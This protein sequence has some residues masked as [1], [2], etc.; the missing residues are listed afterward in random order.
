MPTDDELAELEEQ[1]AQMAKE[2][3]M[4]K[5]K[6]WEGPKVDET[7]ADR[8]RASHVV[9]T[10]YP[11]K[12]N[13]EW[14]PFNLV[15]HFDD[16]KILRYIVGQ[17]E[18]CPKTN[19]VHFQGYC[20]LKKRVQ[21]RKRIQKAL[22]AGKCWC[23][24]AMG[25][26][27]DNFNYC[28]KEHWDGKGNRMAGTQVFEWGKPVVMKG[29]RCDLDDVKLRL[30]AGDNL[31]D[32]AQEH[33][34]PFIKYHKGFEKYQFMKK[35]AEA[36]D[37]RNIKVHVHYGDAGSNKSRSAVEAAGGDYYRP[38]VNKNGQ[39]WFSAYKGEKTLILDDFYGQIP[40]NYLLRL[41]DGHKLEVET[42]GGSTWAMWENVYITSNSHPQFWYRGWVN[43]PEKATHGIK[44][45][46]TTITKHVAKVVH[47][48]WVEETIV[49][50]KVNAVGR[51]L[52]RKN[53]FE[54][55]IG[56]HKKRV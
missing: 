12:K 54:R 30:D 50:H 3:P 27:A 22:S 1:E 24:K 34:K 7:K 56:N 11:S 5:I 40:F 4:V 10:V 19:K 47:S 2:E 16:S 18:T 25:S 52:K 33:F 38:V 8:F 39:V 44:R 21:G 35:T 48:E 13:G 17:F 28:T 41:L 23:Q 46:I 43:I 36:T 31:F 51:G 26:S 15:Q 37:W 55:M 29:Q 9:F 14:N 42:K 6:K 49:N 45:R 53:P 20:Q 32:I